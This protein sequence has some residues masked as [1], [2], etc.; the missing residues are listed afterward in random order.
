LLN[1]YL[2][3]LYKNCYRSIYISGI[4]GT[5]KTATVNEI[6][7]CLKRSVEKGKLDYF[8]FVEINGMKLSEPRQ[9]Y[10][11]ILKQLSGKV[12]TWEQAYNMLEKKFNNKAKRPMTLLLVDEVCYMSL[13]FIY[14]YIYIYT[15]IYLYSLFSI[16][17]FYYLLFYLLDY[18]NF[19]NIILISILFISYSF[20]SFL[21]SLFKFL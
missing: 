16:F 21:F 19:T 12:L 14:I 4:P 5:G 15:H 2:Y 18:I 7:K 17:I 1:I 20:Q 10:V 11:Q 9:A 3:K 6:V 13:F 8:D